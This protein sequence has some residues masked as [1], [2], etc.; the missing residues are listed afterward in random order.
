MG[1]NPFESAPLNQEATPVNPFAIRRTDNPFES[2]PDTASD[3]AD[4]GVGAVAGAH[5]FV[6]S[7]SDLVERGITGPLGIVGEEGPGRLPD[8]KQPIG[9]VPAGSDYEQS[10]ALAGWSS[11]WPHKT[12]S[13]SIPS[14]TA[15]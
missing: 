4:I 8:V 7:I 1:D 13:Q 5:G 2:P 15:L 12:D 14:A 3:I 11:T 6:Q 10:C 9:P